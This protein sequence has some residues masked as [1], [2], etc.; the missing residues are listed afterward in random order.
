MSDSPVSFDPGGPASTARRETVND[1]VNA[2]AV[3]S[4]HPDR[5]GL[6]FTPQHLAEIISAGGDRAASRSLWRVP[7]HSAG[8]GL[9]WYSP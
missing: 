4:R 6:R 1:N 3:K 5:P 7:L 2:P 8:G 9:Q